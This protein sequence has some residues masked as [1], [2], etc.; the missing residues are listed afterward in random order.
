MRLK[1][2]NAFPLAI[3]SGV[4]A[5]GVLLTGCVTR[6]AASPT[7]EFVPT[8]AESAGASPWDKIK[9]S[10]ASS[11]KK[12]V[13]AA[14]PTERRVK[15][16]DPIAL[17]TPQK[18]AGS[19]LYVAAARIHE[20]KGDYAAAA[21]QY[22]RA[23][24]VNGD[25]LTSL[26]GYGHLLDRQHKFTEATLYYERATKAHP[27]S[28]AAWNDLGLC[29]SRRAAADRAMIDRSIAAL[30]RAVEL[31]P[32]KKLYRNNIAAVLVETGRDGEAATH[33][34][35]VHDPAT[36]HY[37]L[38]Y[39]ANQ[40]GRVDAAR[41]YFVEALRLNPQMNAARGFLEQID[42]QGNAIAERQP[43]Q[44]TPRVL[45]V[46]TRSEPS[47]LTPTSGA[48]LVPP[49]A[50]N[51]GAATGRQSVDRGVQTAAVVL[52]LGDVT[53]RAVAPAGY[54][55]AVG[56]SIDSQFEPAVYEDAPEPDDSFGD[57]P[58]PE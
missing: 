55:S 31:K 6:P 47:S 10:F 53:P 13:D 29:Y 28:A 7:S 42:R 43:P 41:Q 11:S 34:L 23:L 50:L 24:A 44:Y 39:L 26:I 58:L 5:S 14:T 37:N 32:E 48:N 15:A 51:R 1:I 18:K 27:D 30:G 16:R 38:G 8:P 4:V 52:P 56:E 12:V 22:E 3:A 35:A 25:D 21:S 45:H 19:D 57:A 49:P 40:Q 20:A 46:P 54:E 2:L 33:L 17:A 36:A 9:A